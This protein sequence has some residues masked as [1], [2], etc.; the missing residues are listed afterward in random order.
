MR[1]GLRL[2]RL[3]R[4][5]LPGIGGLGHLLVGHAR[6]GRPCPP[7]GVDGRSGC[8]DVPGYSRGVILV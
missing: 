3:L 8:A 4:V 7:G 1:L 2:V 5:R 6:D